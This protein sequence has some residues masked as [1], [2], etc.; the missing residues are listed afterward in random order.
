VDDL[1]LAER[2]YHSALGFDKMVTSYPGALFLSAGGY[3]HHL[4][5]NT[6]AAGAPPSTDGDARLLEWTI[7][8]PT[9][10]DVEAAARNCEATGY[11][12]K[13]ELDGWTAV[14]PSGTPLRIARARGSL[15]NG[16]R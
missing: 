7:L 3:H 6:W 2:F 9:P 14:D 11:S 8:L 13:R 4:G 15:E 5:T 12:V 10:A 16:S 1:Q